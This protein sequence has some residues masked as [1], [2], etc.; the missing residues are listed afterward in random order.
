MREGI[1]SALR[2]RGLS[3]AAL[4]STVASLLVLAIVLLITSNLERQAASIESRRVMDVYLAD[5]I[6]ETDRL[7]LE[8]KLQEIPGVASVKHVSKKDA[9]AAFTADTGRYDL[10]EALGYNPLPASFRLELGP[11][12][13]SGPEM[14]AIAE[15][16]ATHPGV[17]DVRY[18]GEW[19]ERLDAALRSLRV[20]DLI[21][22][23]L[24]GLAV[25]FAVS[26][27]IRLT[28]LARRDM[29]EIMKDVGASDA[30][31]CMPFLTEGIAQSLLAALLTLGTLR[32]VT[33]ILSARL[34]ITIH[35]LTAWEAAAFAG[36][37]IVLG[38][39]GAL[40]ST[41]S[42]LKRTG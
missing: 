34:G 21:A 14:R 5:R 35:F 10:V 23:V 24:V 7:T 11:G 32:L 26:S 17:E 33:A 30:T 31:I 40:W 25:V 8:K 16:A 15:S 20:A 27:T 36:F 22:A 18:G 1:H 9:L 38:F 3:A 39:A 37:A 41:G 12:E 42:L 4:V 2:N 29:V 13:A 28:V 19:I 6:T